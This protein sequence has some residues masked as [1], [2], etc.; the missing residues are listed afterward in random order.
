MTMK[1]IL[2]ILDK[3]NYNEINHDTFRN[4]FEAINDNSVIKLSNDLKKILKLNEIDLNE[5]I[6]LGS[7]SYFIVSKSKI[8][9]KYKFP[10]QHNA[11]KFK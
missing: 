9:N 8:T 1:Q 5:I 10:Q 6:S 3:S 2:F 4:K 11:S 7:S